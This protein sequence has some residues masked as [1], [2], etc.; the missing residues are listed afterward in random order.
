MYVRMIRYLDK[1]TPGQVVDLS[2]LRSDI[3]ESI[4]KNGL[5]VVLHDYTPP[6]AKP[7]APPAKPK[8][9]DDLTV[10]ELK[11]LAKAAGI[12]GYST[13]LKADL[14]EALG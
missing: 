14:V 3:A 11:E 8:E 5:G 13:M 2:E 10:A 12:T 1:M 4:I 6:P 9:I 7:A